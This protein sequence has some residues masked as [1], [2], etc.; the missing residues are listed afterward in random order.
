MKNKEKKVFLAVGGT[1]GH[2]YPGISL[3]QKFEEKTGNSV[4]FIINERPLGSSILSERGYKTH[5]IHSAPL[6]RKKIW[7]IC[8]FLYRNMRGLWDSLILLKKN[9]VNVLVAFGS[10]ISVPVVLA[11]YILKIPVILHEQNYFPGMANKFL[12]FAADKIAISYESSTPYFPADKTVLTGNPVR[13]EILETTREEG[14]EFFNFK[15]DK[16]NILIFGGSQ[17]SR[18]INL[19]MYGMLPY[20]EGWREKIQIIHISGDRV[21]ERVKKEYETYDFESRIYKYLDKME[22]AYSVADLIIARAGATTIAE[23]IV[24]SI[25]AILIPYPHASSQHQKLN[26][27]PV[28]KAGLAMYYSESNLSG[29]GLAVR[30]VP[31]LRNANRRK[32]MSLSS[33][34]LKEHFSN[35]SDNLYNLIDQYV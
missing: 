23:I 6:P 35:A 2:I 21:Y 10:Y 18:S 30:V 14:L 15:K 32:N 25:P 1:G 19:T 7:N 9:K 16:I 5:C 22:Y 20:L 3:A 33:R 11:A 26:A 27:K 8:K 34:T 13:Q 28:C 29:A 24:K 31:L 12:S 17:G 4:E